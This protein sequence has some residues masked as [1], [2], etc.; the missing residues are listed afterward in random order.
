MAVVHQRNA[1]ARIGGR[2]AQ[3]ILC[4]AHGI[5]FHADAEHLGFHTGLYLIK[6]EGLGQDFVHALLVAHAGTHPVGRNILEAV[7]CPDVHDA[8]L[9][10]FLCQIA[11]DAD[12][13]LAVLNPETAGLLIGRSQGQR[14][15]HRMGEEGGVEVAAQATLLAIVH[16]LL[17]MLRFQLIPIHPATV[18]FIEN[19]VGGMEV[20]F[21]GA[22]GQR[23]HHINIRHQLFRR[24]G[25]AGIVTG[26]LNT[27]GQRLLRVGVK[28]AN[29]ISLPAMQTN[30]CVAQL[31]HG[32]FHIH[33]NGG[34]TFLCI[35]KLAHW[36]HPFR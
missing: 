24:A 6:V 14:I 23:Q 17:E 4:A 11:A 33:A 3:S 13:G 20:H 15:T 5:G 30:R 22:G 27:A 18:F 32:C 26:G 16:P 35:I 12:A 10:Q 25:T 31:L 7:A 8:G 29:V 2:I 21:L 28:A 9:T 34:I 1:L 19:G 36:F